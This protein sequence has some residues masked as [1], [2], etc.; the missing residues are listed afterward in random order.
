VVLKWWYSGVTVMLP[1]KIDIVRH[2]NRTKYPHSLLDGI[3]A[4]L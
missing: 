3:I 2:D 1:V 4:H